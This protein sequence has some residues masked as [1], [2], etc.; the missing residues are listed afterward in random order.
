MTA[1]RSYPVSLA[2]SLSQIDAF[3]ESFRVWNGLV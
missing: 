2:E 1:V 3:H